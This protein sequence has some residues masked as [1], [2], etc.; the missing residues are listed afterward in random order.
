MTNLGEKPGSWRRRGADGRMCACAGRGRS[1]RGTGI[2]PVG[3]WPL[4]GRGRAPQIGLD[5]VFQREKVGRLFLYLR[6]R[7]FWRD[8]QPSFSSRDPVLSW[9]PRCAPPQ[10]PL[11]HSH[12]PTCLEGK[13]PLSRS[14]DPYRKTHYRQGSRVTTGTASGIHECSGVNET[15]SWNRTCTFSM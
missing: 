12:R 11:E 5:Q 6:V 15:G 14:H 7:A 13:A 3:A 9:A 4:C 10:F 1:L 8:L 2:R